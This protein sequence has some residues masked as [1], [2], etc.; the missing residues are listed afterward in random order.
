M[1]T[2]SKRVIIG[3]KIKRQMCGTLGKK[4][5]PINCDDCLHVDESPGKEKI[6]PTTEFA[7]Y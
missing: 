7:V 2:C 5:N 1:S 3:L 6:H 4:N